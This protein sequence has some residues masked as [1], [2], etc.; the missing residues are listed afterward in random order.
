MLITN[1]CLTKY[2]ITLN[3]Y[4]SGLKL[5]IKKNQLGWLLKPLE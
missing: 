5:N 4:I 3:N 1:L 2:V